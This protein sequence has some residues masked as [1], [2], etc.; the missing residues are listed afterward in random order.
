[1]CFA[2]Y[3]AL[4]LESFWFEL[5]NS[6]DSH[7]ATLFSIYSAML[8]ISSQSRMMRSW[9]RVCHANE[10]ELALVNFVIDDLMPPTATDN[11][12]LQLSVCFICSCTDGA[13]PV[14]TRNH[15][16]GFVIIILRA[17]A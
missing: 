12:P 4:A 7:R 13:H 14:S 10:M 2:A 9:K 3:S 1:M 11:H 15:S 16:I 17:N 8:F 5:W 6:S